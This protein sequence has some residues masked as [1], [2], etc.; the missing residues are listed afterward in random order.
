MNAVT[1]VVVRNVRSARRYPIGTANLLLF[2]PLYQM[3]LPTLL[4]GAAFLV[5]GDAAGLERT[6]GTDDLAAWLTLGMVVSS[7]IVGV[8]WTMVGD[9]STMRATGSLE[10]MLVGSPHPRRLVWGSAVT[11]FLFTLVASLILGVASVWLL[12]ATYFADRLLWLLP[13][14]T[15]LFGAASGYG[16]LLTALIV[17]IRSGEG[18]LDM[19]AYMLAI[20]SGIAFPI[21]VLPQPLLAVSHALPT[22]WT[23]EL[24][25]WALIDGTLM[26]GA[27]TTWILAAVETA[28]FLVLGILAFRHAFS[29]V[30]ELGQF[31]QF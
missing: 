15:L 13:I 31:G 22:T 20:F 1:G 25:R 6:A 9:I 16:F 14:G 2:T 27:P 23:L 7:A 29:R 5:D 26:H 21:A 18:L 4:L 3:V 17:R 8:I 24:L 11:G 10:V 28:L 30:R 19:V 12:D